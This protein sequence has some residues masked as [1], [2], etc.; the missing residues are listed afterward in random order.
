MNKKLFIKI[1]NKMIICYIYKFA[2][3]KEF[4]EN[5][6]IRDIYN[7]FILNILIK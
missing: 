7:N 4:S 2:Y 1:L 5:E 3:F 6:I